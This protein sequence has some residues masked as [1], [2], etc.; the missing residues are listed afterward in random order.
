MLLHALAMWVDA[1]LLIYAGDERSQSNYAGTAAATPLARD[2][3]RLQRGVLSKPPLALC[4][5]VAAA[6]FGAPAAL[7]A[8]RRLRCPCTNMHSRYG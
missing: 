4:R 5:G 2:G 6:T 7:T 1:G 3:R 8:A